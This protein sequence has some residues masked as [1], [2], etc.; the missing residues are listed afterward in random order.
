M[1]ITIA[2]LAVLLFAVSLWFV[3]DHMSL[4][5]KNDA[6]QTSVAKMQS[7]NAQQASMIKTMLSC[8][9]E[10]ERAYQKDKTHVSVSSCI[11]ARMNLN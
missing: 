11:K 1:K 9:N 6:L 10:A 3:F 5:Q 2:L 7:G 8:V 4:V